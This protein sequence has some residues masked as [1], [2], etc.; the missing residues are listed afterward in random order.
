MKLSHLTHKL[1]CPIQKLSH[2]TCKLYHSTYKLP[3]LIHQ[4]PSPTHTLSRPTQNL[5]SPTK[6]MPHST[7]KYFKDSFC[8][9]WGDGSKPRLYWLLV[10][11]IALVRN[12][13]G[14]FFLSFF[15][16]L[17]GLVESGPWEW[18]SMYN[19]RTSR[20]FPGFS[21]GLPFTCLETYHK[22]WGFPFSSFHWSPSNLQVFK[23]FHW[24][25]HKLQVFTG[26]PAFSDMFPRK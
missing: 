26:S 22:I 12:A 18:G 10:Q 17:L 13:V 15:F 23:F 5:S 2:P 25:P 7:H 16:F 14:G 3:R 21:A 20:G 19:L 11:K 6:Q 4:P 9:M 8:S 24:S 1:S